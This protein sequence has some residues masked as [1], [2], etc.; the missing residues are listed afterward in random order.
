M[1]DMNFHIQYNC[2]KIIYVIL[3]PL[4]CL[5]APIHV[6]VCV[7][8]SKHVCIGVYI[9]GSQRTNLA[10]IPQ[11]SSIISSDK[12]S[13]NGM[14]FTKE[15]NDFRS[16]CPCLRHFLEFIFNIFQ[17]LGSGGRRIWNSRLVWATHKFEGLHETQ[18][19]IE[20]GTS[21]SFRCL[22]PEMCDSFLPRT[23]FELFG[24]SSSRLQYPTQLIP[25]Q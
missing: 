11:I 19:Q 10:I 18:F 16:V 12:G 22:N 9:S 14:L 23:G 3:L 21:W 5:F 6:C 8:I 7:G 25:F 13:F 4:L 15:A 20:I 2:I 17:H 24:D 1:T